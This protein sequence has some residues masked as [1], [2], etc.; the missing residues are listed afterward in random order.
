MVASTVYVFPKNFLIVLT[1]AGDSTII[2]LFAIYTLT[3]L[4][5]KN[6]VLRAHIL[7]FSVLQR[8]ERQNLCTRRCMRDPHFGTDNAYIRK[9]IPPSVNRGQYTTL[10]F[11]LQGT[12]MKTI[13]R[14]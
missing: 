2:K 5:E 11:I 10:F 9:V 7:Q 3:F 6:P 12:V 4:P 14:Y 13:F 1:F 8:N